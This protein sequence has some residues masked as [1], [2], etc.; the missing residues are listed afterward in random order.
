M[1]RINERLRARHV[2]APT[3]D[4]AASA[5]NQA[6]A[7]AAAAKASEAL[8]RKQAIIRAG[9]QVERAARI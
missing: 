4:A 9:Q 6:A 5:A 3:A 2:E 7:A 1:R 8:K